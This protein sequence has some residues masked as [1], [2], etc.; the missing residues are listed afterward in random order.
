VSATLVSVDAVLR[1][2]VHDDACARR[3]V[4]DMPSEVVGGIPRQPVWSALTELVTEGVVIDPNVVLARV[5]ACR[6]PG[7]DDA[8]RWMASL[9]EGGPAAGTLGW[10]LD[11]LAEEATRL[12]LVALSVS[13]AQAAE[14]DDIGGAVEFLRERLD[15]VRIGGT[16]TPP[17]LAD[18]VPEFLERLETQD[19][20]RVLSTGLSDLDSLLNGG[21]RAG[22][23]VIVGARPGVGKSVLLGDMARHAALHQDAR[24]AFYALEMD[25][26]ELTARFVSAQTRVSL[27][28]ISRRECTDA[29]WSRIARATAPLSHGHLHIIDEAMQTVDSITTGARGIRPDLLVV[30]YLGLVTSKGK[31]SNR[32]EEVAALSRGLKRA[33]RDLGCPVVVAAQLN[34]GLE[35]RTDPTPRLSDLRESGGIEAD[36]DVVILLD[37]RE[38]DE[39]MGTTAR[40][41]VAKNRSGPTGA[42]DLAFL[43]SYV[44]FM[45]LSKWGD[46]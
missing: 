46:A 37:R 39:T 27:S 40:A 32:Q 18:L 9:I 13:T 38:D 6:E 12:R 22:Q 15:R 17:T 20:S 16:I 43:G 28:H 8:A 14:Q 31:A 23:L 25:R 24:V 29:D 26:Q 35:S 33:A 11:R 34:R 45:P 41:H 44:T 42:V 36:A 21:L 3:A 4:A 10:H 30:D 1:S 7:W 19:T 5:M 2:A